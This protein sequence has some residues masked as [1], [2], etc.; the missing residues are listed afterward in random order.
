MKTLLSALRLLLLFPVARRHLVHLGFLALFST[1]LL[2]FW[3]QRHEGLFHTPKAQS[4]RFRALEW[5]V[6]NLYDTLH[7]VGFDDREFLPNAERRWNT[8]RYFHKQ[9]SLAKTILAAG[10][11]QPVDLVALCEVEN[12]SVMHFLCRRTRLAR[13]GYEYLVTHSAD[14]RG[15]DVALLY[16]PE[17]FAL[18]HSET[19][20][21]PYDSLRERPTRDLLHAAGR[22]PF[23]DTLDVF[24]VH[25]PS[26]RGGATLS[27][28][29]RLR[30]AGILRHLADRS[31]A[32][33]ILRAYWPWGISMTSPTTLL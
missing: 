33:D 7:D 28:P 16:Q 31:P 25:F 6:E 9:S 19:Y 30:A 11:L 4:A 3:G 24:V 12:D 2:P 17:T 26:R 22:L 27:E 18:L 23:G 21:V 10:G 1:W 8:P 14:R 20:R 13:L 29:Y 15:I 32:A 5:N